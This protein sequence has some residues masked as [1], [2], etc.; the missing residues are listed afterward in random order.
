MRKWS[1]N[2]RGGGL[3]LEAT[4]KFKVCESCGSIVARRTCV[5]PNCN[6][7]RFDSKVA[8]VT[9]QARLL[10]ERNPLSIKQEDYV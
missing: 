2:A 3:G 10:G 7:Y 1:R 6:G 8:A 4:Q 9:A 5:C